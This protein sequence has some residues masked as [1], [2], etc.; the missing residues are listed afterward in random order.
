MECLEGIAA[1]FAKKDQEILDIENKIKRVTED[2]AF[3]VGLV[4]QRDTE[5]NRLTEKLRETKKALDAA[6]TH[7]AK[8][9]SKSKQIE[10]RCEE[11]E[12]RIDEHL[13]EEE[14]AQ[15]LLNQAKDEFESTRTS[16]NESRKKLQEEAMRKAQ[17]MELQKARLVNAIQLD[18]QKI[19][20]LQQ[21]AK[22]MRETVSTMLTE[23][24]TSHND[25]MSKLT[26]QIEQLEKGNEELIEALHD[27]QQRARSEVTERQKQL[28]NLMYQKAE[29]DKERTAERK[30]KLRELQCDLDTKRNK[31][32]S[33]QRE[34]ETLSQS[35]KSREAVIE[36]LRVRYEATESKI[37]AQADEVRRARKA[38]KQEMDKLKQELSSAK[39]A[40]RNNKQRLEE[41]RRAH[42]NDQEEWK[43]N[44]LAIQQYKATLDNQYT[45]L[46]TKTENA[47]AKLR[48][49]DNL[50]N[51]LSVKSGSLKQRAKSAAEELQRQHNE[52]LRLKQVLDDKREALADLKGQI[53]K[54]RS[55]RRERLV[56]PRMSTIQVPPKIDIPQQPLPGSDIGN[57][58]SDFGIASA[59]PDIFALSPIG[60]EV[61]SFHGN[62][63]VIELKAQLEDVKKTSEELAL[64]LQAK[65]EEIEAKK[66][67]GSRLEELLKENA[68]LKAQK[69]EMDR[70][71]EEI[72]KYRQQRPAM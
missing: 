58:T 20:E 70:M 71:K 14:Q 36:E 7:E 50:L 67:A 28:Q 6:H 8:V 64:H 19:L 53:A 43:R 45:A 30:A 56:N 68:R 40:E 39:Q 44:Q 69:E 52:A 4:Q 41:L 2:L 49:A 1:A 31:K 54:V 34:I 10:H 18:E 48:D 63:Q 35:R 66:G 62:D 47:V 46:R 5:I 32:L 42:F 37:Q 33:L 38:Q 26:S 13:K 61:P 72:S 65:R 51:E 29:F 17:E 16:V 60:S 15:L 59:N 57:L 3:N 24:Y 12:K 27:A 22:Q 55:E 21:I 9:E 11:L 25:E 23:L